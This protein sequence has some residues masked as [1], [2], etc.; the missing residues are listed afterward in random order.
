MSISN[1]AE[2]KLLDTFRNVSY[3]V[4]ATYVQLHTGDPGE[5]GTSNVASNGGRL[6]VTFNA[7]S[8]GSMVS[9]AA[10]TWT[11]VS[12]S[13]TYSHFT[14]WDNSTGGNCLWIGPFS[15]SATVV[16]GDNFQI[17]SLTLTMD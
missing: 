4:A 17:T 14:L 1:Y 9:A 8:G 12:T 2:N 7:A 5:D 3:A 16:A 15:T 11:N 13:E 6:A 10:V